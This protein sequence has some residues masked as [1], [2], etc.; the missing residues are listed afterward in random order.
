MSFGYEVRMILST[1]TLTC[2]TSATD[3]S[4][5]ML[6]FAE[7]FMHVTDDGIDAS[8]RLFFCLYDHEDFRD[9][10]DAFL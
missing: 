7:Y 2:L 5:R 9:T 1:P 8:R 10:L 4:N 3:I 6:P